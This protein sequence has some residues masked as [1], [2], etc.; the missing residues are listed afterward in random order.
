MLATL[1][2]LLGQICDDVELVGRDGTTASFTLS[3]LN[4]PSSLLGSKHC[5][6]VHGLPRWVQFPIF[7]C[8][9]PQKYLMAYDEKYESSF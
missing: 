7:R 3:V 9:F 5:K 6:V 1:G 4:R 8:R 2:L